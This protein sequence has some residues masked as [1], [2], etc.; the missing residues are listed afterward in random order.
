MDKSWQCVA[1]G[2]LRGV[3]S[4]SEERP[5]RTRRV[6]TFFS[7]DGSEVS[8]EEEGVKK[9]R[10]AEISTAY[11]RASNVRLVYLSHLMYLCSL[12]DMLRLYRISAFN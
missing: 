7:G 9:A 11:N 10:K 4:F 12:Q 5:G 3:S 1:A 6:K 8:R 2:Q